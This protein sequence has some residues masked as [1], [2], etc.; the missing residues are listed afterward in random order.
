[1]LVPV[2]AAAAILS[3][4]NAKG[5]TF[6]VDLDNLNNLKPLL[7]LREQGHD[8]G[9][10]LSLEDLGASGNISADDVDSIMP[11]LDSAATIMREL[12]SDYPT[13]YFD[14][15]FN[16]NSVASMA[17]AYRIFAG[18]T[19]I[20]LLRLEL[21]EIFPVVVP[22]KVSFE[23]YRSRQLGQSPIVDTARKAL[24]MAAIDP[25]GAGVFEIDACRSE[26]GWWVFA[27]GTEEETLD[28][29][30]G[31]GL[32]NIHPTPINEVVGNIINS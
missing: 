19:T 7:S 4:D 2:E 30:D 15:E 31:F 6:L 10:R 9:V 23:R 20:E 25:G 14:L 21:L 1:M 5:L 13:L 22:Y 11:F 3:Q 29:L 28:L 26:S 8:L 27:P 12:G 18:N 17:D 32:F 16:K 24:T